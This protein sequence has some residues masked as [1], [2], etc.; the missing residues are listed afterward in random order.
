MGV[1]ADTGGGPKML[2]DFLRCLCNYEH[3][4]SNSSAS[5]GNTCLSD[6]VMNIGTCSL[7]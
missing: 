2:K 1:N 7:F 5:G 6:M 4:Q 3:I